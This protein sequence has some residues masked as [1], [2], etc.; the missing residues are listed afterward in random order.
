MWLFFLLCLL[1]LGFFVLAYFKE[2]RSIFI[3]LLVVNLFIWLGIWILSA[4][5]LETNDI[6]RLLGI[7]IFATFLLCLML[8]P[9][10]F[11]CALYYN[12]FKLLKSEGVRF[13]NFLSLG[14]ALAITFYSFIFPF[15]TKYLSSIPVLNYFFFYLG[16]LVAY[17]VG[18]SILYTS[19]SFVNLIN[20]LPPKLDYVVVLGAGLIGE[21]VTPLL[22]SR[23]DRGIAIYRKNPGS[24][25]IM[26]GGQGP[27]EVIAEAQAMAN[28][29]LVKGVAADDIIL[30]NKS[31]NTK[32]NIKFSRNLMTNGSQ[33]ALVTNYYH[34]FRALLIARQL[35]IK[36]I[37]YGAKTK[38]Y[39]SLNAFIREFVGYLVYTKKWHMTILG[40]LTFVFIIGTI[41]THL[42][43]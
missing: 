17:L 28:Y 33:F 29:A 32:E 37:G 18:L 19:S 41:L 25:L 22:A 21:Q 35:G 24:K 12:G 9:F 7:A 3:A 26:S 13:Q 38:F 5:I 6:L 30:E 16:I 11:L 31:T 23:I 20:I 43:Q 2:R 15:I 10:F 4:R 40:V 27:D 34:V 14:L 36:C 8:G 1:S 39:F 42:I